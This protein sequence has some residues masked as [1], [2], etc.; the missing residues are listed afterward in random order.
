MILL[1]KSFFSWTGVHAVT[2]MFLEKR[3]DEDLGTRRV[4]A[5]L[6]AI[7]TEA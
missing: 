5:S 1:V 4:F 3:S 7:A 6:R 2:R